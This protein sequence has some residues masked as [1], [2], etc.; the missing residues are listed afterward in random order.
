MAAVNPDFTSQSPAPR[1]A[2]QLGAQSNPGE[3]EWW[4]LCGGGH[5]ILHPGPSPS[6]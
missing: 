6:P 1:C 5:H 3:G 2:A 4:L